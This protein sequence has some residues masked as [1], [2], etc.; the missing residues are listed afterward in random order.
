MSDN[1]IDELLPEDGLPEDMHVEDYDDAAP[2]ASIDQQLFVEWLH[3]GQYDCDVARCLGVAWARDLCG[4]GQESLVDFFKLFCTI[5]RWMCK[6]VPL[7]QKM[8]LMRLTRYQ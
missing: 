8:S 5:I 4:S 7:F 6:Q 2:Q 1:E 3:E